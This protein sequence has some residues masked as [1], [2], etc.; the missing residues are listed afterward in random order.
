MVENRSRSATDIESDAWGRA[1]GTSR[2]KLSVTTKPPSTVLSPRTVGP[3]AVGGVQTYAG[4]VFIT[5]VVEYPR[6][7]PVHCFVSPSLHCSTLRVVIDAAMVECTTLEEWRGWLREH[8]C[9]ATGVW[10][11]YHKK[12]SP[13][14]SLSY[15][16]MVS[17]AL[18]WGWVDSRPGTVDDYRGKLYFA[19]RKKT[20]GWSAKNKQ[21]IEI[22]IKEGRMQAAGL[23]LVEEAKASGTWTALDAVEQLAI[24]DDLAVAFAAHPGS[25]ENFE[26]FSRTNKRMV[27]EWIAQ[28][29]KPET[30]ATRITTTAEKAALNE[31]ANLWR[32]S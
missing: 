16:E 7:Q 14:P 20:S 18:C 10:L 25:Q 28:A 9:G 5:I 8:H 13:L 3:A 11:V 26:D 1:S 30:R 31:V 22:L 4:L 32:K 27:L 29:K 17:E 21:R 19:P 12:A 6:H 24:P 15:D 2:G 23:A